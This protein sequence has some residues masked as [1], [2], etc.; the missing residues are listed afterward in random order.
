MYLLVNLLVLYKIVGF[1]YLN[2]I[3]CSINIVI[4]ISFINLKK[5]L[6]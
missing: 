3:Y 1:L 6:I 2:L 4:E 5:V